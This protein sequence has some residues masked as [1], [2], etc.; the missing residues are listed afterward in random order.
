MKQR[1]RF[2]GASVRYSSRMITEKG[3]FTAI[4]RYSRKTRT[5]DVIRSSTN[6]STAIR[7]KAWA[8]A[9]KRGGQGWSLNYSSRAVGRISNTFA[10]RVARKQYGCS[11]GQDCR[12]YP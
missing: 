9:T 5:F 1:G 10:R 7:A 4:A 2:R 11:D 12:R 6:F 8:P 3:P